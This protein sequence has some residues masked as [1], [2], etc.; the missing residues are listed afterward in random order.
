M[1][2]ANLIYTGPVPVSLAAPVYCLF[3]S[4]H[5]LCWWIPHNSV[6]LKWI[7]PLFPWSHLLIR[8]HSV[9]TG[10]SGRDLWGQLRAGCSGLQWEMWKTFAPESK[11]AIG[12]E[13][14]HPWPCIL[15]LGP[16]LL[17]SVNLCSPIFPPSFQQAPQY[18]CFVPL[19]CCLSPKILSVI[20]WPK[21]WQTACH[22]S[23][24]LV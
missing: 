23:A 16:I 17:V 10:P 2:A 7:L 11:H 18:H 12:S 5:S 20:E 22:V 6:L 14:E 21:I 8:L 24:V 3:I 1:H 4:I 9:Q 19:C 15:H 13:S